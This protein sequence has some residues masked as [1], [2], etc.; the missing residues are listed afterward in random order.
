M[1]QELI[2][3]IIDH[4]IAG[5][6]GEFGN[7]N[8]RVRPGPITDPTQSA[9]PKWAVEMAELRTLTSP[10]DDSSAQPRP[11]EGREAIAVNGGNPAGPYALG[12]QPLEGSVEMKVVY[13][14]GLVSE[15]SET[16]LPGIDFTVD[17]QASE[18]TVV[19]DIT[20]ASVLRVKYSF[21]GIATIQ[22][23]EQDFHISVYLDTW[24][25]TD[26]WLGLPLSI[27]QSR[28]A[29]IV[30]QFNFLQPTNINVNSFMAQPF[31]QKVRFL[32]MD[33]VPRTSR[34]RLAEI[35]WLMHF[36][37]KG[38]LRLGQSLSGGFGIISNIHTRGAS[39]PGVD[40]RPDLG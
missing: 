37:V 26:K 20:G 35:N 9:R 11:V 6:A 17:L 18:F 34:Q 28:H 3:I 38:Q 23:F 14:E 29:E 15:Y 31:I 16:L 13:D 1:I 33:Q 40:I 21:V 8:A 5:L 7:L 4:L 27:I 12:S 30:E 10:P 39:G 2:Q 32:R 24:T 36:Q 22:E 19:K 25:D